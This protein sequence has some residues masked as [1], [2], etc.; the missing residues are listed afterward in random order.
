[1]LHSSDLF[2]KVCVVN[3]T[4]DLNLSVLNMITGINELKNWTKDISCE[5][6][7]SFDGKWWN[8]DKCLCESKKHHVC[9][10][11]YIWN[12]DTSSCEMEN[13]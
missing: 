12:L 9:E 8:N 13:I 5:C 7:C 1:M 6:K 11:Y 3:K 10:K 4:E 2:N